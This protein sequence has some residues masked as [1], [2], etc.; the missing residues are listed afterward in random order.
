MI[1]PTISFIIHIFINSIK[2]YGPA[3]RL[4][5]YLIPYARMSS[6]A[7]Q[8]KNFNSK[9]LKKG[10]PLPPYNGV[11]RLYNM[12]YCPWAQRTVLILNAKQVP[13]EVVNI[14][15][16]EKPEWLV[17][18]SPFTKV[19]SIEIEENIVVYESAV[20]ADYLEDVYTDRP[21][22]P[23][24]PLKRAQDKLVLEH[25]S[26][27]TGIFYRVLKCPDTLDD[28]SKADFYGVLEY[29]QNLLVKRNTNFIYSDDQ[30]GYAD[31]LIWPWF[32]RLPVLIKFS[33][34]ALEIPKDKFERLLTYIENMKKDPA[35]SQYLLD[36]ST[37]VK[38]INNYISGSPQYDDL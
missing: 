29:I 3:A 14:N 37:H 2:A 25:F 11:L 19:P 33:K 17:T 9:H 10:D 22:L 35:V 34:G 36:E 6:K 32:E 4:V 12:R 13:Y 5:E 1:S 21:L 26:K 15:L 23:K 7:V 24:D 20:T 27:L 28:E 16:I 31:Y 38:F 30:P 18:K 8:G